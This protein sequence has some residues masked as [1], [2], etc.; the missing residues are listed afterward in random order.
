MQQNFDLKT[1][2]QYWKSEDE[3]NENLQGGKSSDDVRRI[4]IWRREASEVVPFDS[5]ETSGFVLGDE[6]Q[7]EG[8]VLDG[9]GAS[10]AW[11][12]V[13]FGVLRLYRFW[14]RHR[15]MRVSAAGGG[16]ERRRRSRDGEEFAEVV[17]VKGEESEDGGHEKIT[18]EWECSKCEGS[19]R[20]R[21]RRTKDSEGQQCN[22]TTIERLW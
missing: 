16:S 13:R 19:R 5:L 14:S 6:A 11:R 7:P 3:G 4:R 12:T 1:L 2:T 17:R 9:F 20:R 8:L 10:L 22:F 18:I 21:R 15:K